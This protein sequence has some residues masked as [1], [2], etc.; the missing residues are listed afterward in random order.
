M[1]PLWPKKEKKM[2][3]KTIKDLVFASIII[4]IIVALTAT[5]WGFINV[6]L[7]SAI[8][9][10]HIPVLVGT[11]VLGKKYGLL[12]GTVFGLSSMVLAFFTLGPNAPFTNPILS[13]LPR[14]LFGF[15]IYPLYKFFIKR[16]NSK[17]IAI[18]IAVVISYFIHSVLVIAI[19]FFVGK[20]GFYFGAE[21]NPWN[22]NDSF[23]IFMLAI[24]SI[25]TLIELV[26]AVV[27]GTPSIMVLNDLRNREEGE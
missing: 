9:I 24:F 12:L 25:N 11:V 3:N 20:S 27:I 6:G 8:T 2:R 19:L 17:P 22:N 7:L 1:G 23:A 21:G 10:I 16:I 4:G 15:I 18:S 5:Q 13:V 14:A 26:L